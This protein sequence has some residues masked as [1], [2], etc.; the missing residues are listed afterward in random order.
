MAIEEINALTD[1]EVELVEFKEGSVIKDLQFT[2]KRPK[3]LALELDPPFIARYT[4]VCNALAAR[5]TAGRASKAACEP[6]GW[7]QTGA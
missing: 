4:G 1:L 5:S 7:C 6:C 3:Q 2:V